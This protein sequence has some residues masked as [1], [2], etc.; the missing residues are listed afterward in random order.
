MIRE[1]L[2]RIPPARRESPAVQN[3]MADAELL[4][5]PVW[6]AQLVTLIA[7]YDA[8]PC[9]AT[10]CAAQCGRRASALCRW[11]LICAKTV[12]PTV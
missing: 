3:L 2:S 10:L 5:D 12:D 1:I 11:C 4:N 6:A 9:T 7:V 8:D